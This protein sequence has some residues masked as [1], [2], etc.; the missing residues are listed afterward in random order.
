MTALT[1][2]PVGLVGAGDPNNTS[3]T[4]GSTDTRTKRHLVHRISRVL[5]Q[6]V[7]TLRLEKPNY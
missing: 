5:V 7:V 2:I 6:Y 1:Y 3:R 4:M